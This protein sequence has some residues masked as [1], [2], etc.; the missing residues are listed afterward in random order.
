MRAR[1]SSSAFTNV[2]PSDAAALRV[3]LVF[4]GRPASGG[5]D[6]VAGLF[7]ALQLRAGN[8]TTTGTATTAT[9][10]A[11]AGGGGLGGG[12]RSSSELI[13]FI[14]GTVGLLEGH[15]VTLTPA[16]IFAYRNAGGFELLGRSEDLTRMSEPK[17][18]AVVAD[19]CHT[20]R[21]DVLVLV[22]GAR[23]STQ[24]AYL[25]EYF[26]STGQ[27]STRIITAPIDMAGSLKNEFVET[28]VGFD[29]ASK[30]AAQIVGNNA[31]DGAS[32]KKYY[33]FMR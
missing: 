1:L 23:T 17:V 29:T 21:L 33:Y 15:A 20:H 24:A 7:D 6:F 2:P 27:S 16:S 4:C 13:G 5:H 22:G 18:C 11:A 28:S 32:A 14:G 8:T 9:T 12:A 30:V 31:T 19:T 10:A 25:A 3:G 26:A